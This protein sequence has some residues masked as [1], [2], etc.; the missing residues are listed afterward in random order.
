MLKF[1][2]P[3]LLIPSIALAEAEITA[4]RVVGGWDITQHHDAGTYTHCTMATTFNAQNTKQKKEMRADF[5]AL[6]F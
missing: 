2:I 6:M 3:F 4:S 1:L 5:M